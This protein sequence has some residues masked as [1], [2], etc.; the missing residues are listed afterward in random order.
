MSN[1]R[2]L[3]KQMKTDGEVSAFIEAQYQT[4]LDLNKKNSDLEGEVQHLKSMLNNVIPN[5]IMSKISNPNSPSE[6]LI[7]EIQL[8]RLNQTSMERELTAEEVTKVEKLSKI[9]Q[10]FRKVDKVKGQ[11]DLSEKPTAELLKLV[12]NDE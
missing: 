4:I 9:I 7:A 10:T 6:Q 8:G 1:I 3:I 5:D 12:Q 2:D 11:E